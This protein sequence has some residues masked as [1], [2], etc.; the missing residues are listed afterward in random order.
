MVH[1]NF[2]SL[3]I[4]AE[5]GV[6]F[7]T[8]NHPPLN[9]LDA[10]LMQQLDALAA[11]L[12]TDD[13]IRVVVFDSAD[14]DFFIP[15]GDMDF[16]KSPE[17]FSKLELGDEHTRGLN[18]MMRLHERIRTLPQITIGKLSGLARGGGQRAVGCGR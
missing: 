3:Q 7:V 16:V 18:P 9:L 2:P 6:A 14:A 10:S 12:Q 1:Q 15:H 5:H 8:L 11:S 4:R 17:A 13:G